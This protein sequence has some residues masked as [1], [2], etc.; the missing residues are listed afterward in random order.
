MCLVS[1]QGEGGEQKGKLKE[2]EN[3]LKNRVALTSSECRLA[4]N[5][6][7]FEGISLHRVCT[8][9]NRT[10]RLVEFSNGELVGGCTTSPGKETI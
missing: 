9:R 10:R 2:S 7:Y 5:T 8:Y 1:A 3:T 6:K 4:C